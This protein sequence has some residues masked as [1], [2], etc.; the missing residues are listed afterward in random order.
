MLSHSP[1][2]LTIVDSEPLS[3]DHYRVHTVNP[4]DDTVYG[5]QTYPADASGTTIIPIGTNG[6]LDSVP[7]NSLFNLLVVEMK[8][9]I[10]SAAGFQAAPG[11]PFTN[12]LLPDGAESISVTV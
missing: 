8:D 4:E 9:G 5:E 7:V 11:G 6:L 1:K 2:L 12:V 3:V 10:D